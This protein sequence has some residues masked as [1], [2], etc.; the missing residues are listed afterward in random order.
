MVLPLRVPREL[1]PVEVHVAEVA[2]RIPRRLVVEMLRR[3]VPALAAGGDGARTNPGTEFDDGDETVA[4]RAVPLLGVRIRARAERRERSPVRGRE[5]DRDAGLGVV[6]V[7]GDR[8]VEPLEAIDVAPGRP[9][10][11]E[12]S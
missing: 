2:G 8:V 5:V 7:R 12:V 10:G 3:R 1:V 6:E 11:S 4:A 9:P